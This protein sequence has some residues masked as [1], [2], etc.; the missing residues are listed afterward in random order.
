M[1]FA[2]SDRCEDY[3]KR[4]SAFMDEHVYRGAEIYEEQHQAFGPEGRWKVPPVIEEL[5]AKARDAG[6][7]NLFHPNPEFGP[8]LSNRVQVQV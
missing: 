1:E 2:Y 5:K 8:G 4:V 6:L 7:W 3:L